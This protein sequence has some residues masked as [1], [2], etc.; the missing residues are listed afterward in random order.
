ML[1]RHL[2]VQGFGCFE[3]L[4]IELGPGLNVIS[5]PNEAG[6]STLHRA[7]L[8]LL[9]EKA[10]REQRTWGHEGMYIL[11]ATLQ[12]GAQT[13]ELTKDFEQKQTL[14]VEHGGE[15]LSGTKAETRLAGLVGTDSA[16]LYAATASLS[17]ADW[18]HL[19]ETGD[20]KEH[21]QS[22]V[23][24]GADGVAA[25]RVLKKI[26]ATL[27][28]LLRGTRGAA[29]KEGGD[30]AQAEE[31]LQQIEAQLATIGAQVRAADEAATTVTECEAELGPLRGEV[32]ALKDAVDHASQLQEAESARAEALEQISALDK[33][34][35]EAEKLQ[36]QISNLQTQMGKLPAIT[37]A[38]AGEVSGLAA[39]ISRMEEQLA[40]TEQHLTDLASQ[41][42]Q[43]MAQSA[44]GLH[45]RAA[46]LGLSIAGSV[47]AVIGILGF[48]L[49]TTWLLALAAIG[50]A[51]VIAA[52]AL[53]L[54]ANLAGE[55][56]RIALERE[57][58]K[59][60]EQQTNLRSKL[61]AARGG[62]QERL[63]AL[64]V[65]SAE[66][67]A[68][69]AQERAELEGQME[70]AR[71]ALSGVLMGQI[72]GKLREDRTELRLEYEKWDE[73][74]KRPEIA[75][76]ESDPVKLERLR[77][78]LTAKENRIEELDTQLREAQ[79][80]LKNVSVDAEDVMRIE[81]QKRAIEERLERLRERVAVLELTRDLITEA[82]SQTLRPWTEGLQPRMGEYLAQLTEDRYGEV[83]IDEG[84]LEPLVISPQTSDE[85]NPD[86]AY[87]L[88]CATKDQVYLAARLAL[89]ELLW[90]GR[91]G[92][93]LLLDDPLVNFDAGR[94]TAAI[95]LLQRLAGSR[96]LILF[97][98][99][100][101]YDEAADNLVELKPTDLLTENPT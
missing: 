71:A 85:L 83:R 62:L 97:T 34:L 17:Q 50:V 56:N 38:A 14:L 82:Y 31:E 70:V 88:S 87:D 94:K 81:E 44:G 63:Q 15:T 28:D 19:S 32:N 64:G 10:I 89:T 77:S 99:S 3:D 92:P 1:L 75:Q 42:E 43:A 49:G 55:A 29:Y 48:V 65:E 47:L 8:V 40:E 13:Y 4:S 80:Q 100:A 59:F 22:T 11:S 30:I 35:D 46:R 73:E 95:R 84:E 101:E 20:I 60:Q 90:Q 2:H 78:D 5:G 25:E 33:R 9:A 57:I 24:G 6:K 61:E 91:E 93:P 96:Q 52:V 7:I 45:S 51:A 53:R 16:R 67:A 12:D 39:Q 18:A 54:Q 26:A 69:I 37:V 76:A 27:D 86:A 74:L 41:L 98:C 68:Q 36:Q 66:K 79:W 72:T 21:L 23:T 58:N